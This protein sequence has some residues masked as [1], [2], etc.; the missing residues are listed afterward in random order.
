MNNLTF[1][2]ISKQ[3]MAI[4]VRLFWDTAYRDEKVFT[5]N[6]IKE[7][8]PKDYKY[9]W[10]FIS[11]LKKKKILNTIKRGIYTINPLDSLPFGRNLQ[12]MSVADVYMGGRE[13]YV[14]YSSLFNWYGFSEQIFQDIYVINQSISL[15]KNNKQHSI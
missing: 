4:C 15:K 5:T 13:Y 8:L 10:Q 7:Y 14:G 12:G 6:K 3:E 1:P 2:N 11:R 9:T